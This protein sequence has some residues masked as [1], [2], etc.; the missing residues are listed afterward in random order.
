MPDKLYIPVILGTIREGRASEAVAHFMHTQLLAL[1][2]VQTKL[3]DIRTLDM[4]WTDEGPA[5]AARN[6]G[7]VDDITRADGLLI[8][9]PEYNHSFPGSLKRVLDICL[10]EYEHK[11]AGVVGVSS[12]TIGGAR[13]VEHLSTVLRYLGLS[14]T[15]TDMLFPQAKTAFS[16]DGSPKDEKIL[17][18][19]AA[20]LNELTFLAK[21]LKQG[22]E[23]VE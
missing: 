5:L 10:K 18:R 3:I 15:K 20:F 4:P 9:S 23:N 19:C 7:F 1:P 11:A 21:A 13:M 8:V 14:V 22:R 17:E 2:N 6:Q 12:G 16:E